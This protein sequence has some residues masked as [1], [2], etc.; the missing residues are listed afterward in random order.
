M[1]HIAKG[2]PV[3]FDFH[4]L[5]IT[6]FG[7]PQSDSASLAVIDVPPGAKHPK[8]RSTKS[9]KFYFCLEGPVSFV[10]EKQEVS[11]QT[12]DLLVISKG[13]WFSY[14]NPADKQAKL[15]LVHVPPFDLNAEV[16]EGE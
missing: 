4:G 9:D 8:A 12:S 6:D 15:L 2:K 13:E 16:I 10:V 14:S 11:L 1:K 5:K 3:P 7:P